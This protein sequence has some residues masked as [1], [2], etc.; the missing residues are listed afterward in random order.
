MS[1]A[2]PDS[3]K[4]ESLRKNMQLLS[5]VPQE[6]EDG[7]AYYL[8]A[9]GLEFS[10]ISGDIFYSGGF[11]RS[12][13]L[14]ISC[15]L[16]RQHSNK[17]TVVLLHGYFDHVGLYGHIIRFYLEQGFSVFTYDQIGHG[18][19]C[20]DRANIDSF[21]SYTRVLR[22]CLDWCKKA[23]LPKP[24]HLSGQS[25]GGA[26]V[27]EFLAGERCTKDEYSIDKVIL[28]APLIRPVL[29]R[30]GRIQYQLVRRFIS[31]VPR[32]RSNNSNDHEFLEFLAREP[33]QSRTLPVGWVGAMSR[34]IKKI[35][36]IAK[37]CGFDALIIQGQKDGTVDWQHNMPV[38]KRLY[39]S[40]D[41]FYIPEGQHHL[42]N[43]SEEIRQRYMG[44][45]LN[46]L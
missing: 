9:Y 18:L 30:W 28:F 10:D 5:P 36:S 17:G 21:S 1:R 3:E 8:K 16:W 4:L 32:S 44:W 34:W 29:W 31:S 39:K 38:Y 37:P 11:L 42:V 14:K 35:E 12:G 24:F 33:L 20:G 19:S 25:M 2:I 46:K 15:H 40:V 27:S 23:D 13:D 22:M 41:V 26:I 45:L 7:R 6:F 43:E